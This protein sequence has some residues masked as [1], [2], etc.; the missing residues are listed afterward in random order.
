MVVEISGKKIDRE[1]KITTG[2]TWVMLKNTKTKIRENSSPLYQIYTPTLNSP[3]EKK[4]NQKRTIIQEAS[5]SPLHT[6]KYYL[7]KKS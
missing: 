1:G 4:Q 7:K 2:K 5:G 3:P 6:F